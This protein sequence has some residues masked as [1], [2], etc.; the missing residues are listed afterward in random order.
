MFI[1]LSSTQEYYRIL[2]L[3]TLVFIALACI[4]SLV[5]IS[6]IYRPSDYFTH[7][8][9]DIAILYQRTQVSF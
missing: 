5:L 6:N 1:H 9:T 2:K 4:A 7:A 8:G 3:D